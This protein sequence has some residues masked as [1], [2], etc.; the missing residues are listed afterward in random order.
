MINY[1]STASMG[2]SGA[3]ISGMKYG[4][5]RLVDGLCRRFW[6]EDAEHHLDS[7]LNY[8]EPE[9]TREIPGEIPD[10]ITEAAE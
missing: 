2:L 8:A 10:A 5:M 9:L 4:T 7:L 6:L 1:G 3:T